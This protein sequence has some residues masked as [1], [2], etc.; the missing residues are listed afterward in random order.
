MFQN[1]TSKPNIFDPVVLNQLLAQFTT[2]APHFCVRLH[3]VSMIGGMAFDGPVPPGPPLREGG[4]PNG[5]AALLQQK[6][7]RQRQL[8][9]E[10]QRSA[11]RKQLGAGVIASASPMQPSP[12][13]AKDWDQVLPELS[14]S[15]TAP[16][17]DARP[18]NSEHKTAPSSP[19]EE[20]ERPEPVKSGT[21][22][23]LDDALDG[24]A[25]EL[26]LDERLPQ[27]AKRGSLEDS[28]GVPWPTRNADGRGKS[29]FGEAKAP[30]PS[31]SLAGIEEDNLYE[32]SFEL[33]ASRPA[34]GM[35]RK[36]QTLILEDGMEQA[37]APSA[38]GLTPTLGRGHTG[39]GHG[40]PQSSGAPSVGKSWDLTVEGA[41]DRVEPVGRR[42]KAEGRSWWPFGGGGGGRD[43]ASTAPVEVKE[44]E[45]GYRGHCHFVLQLRLGVFFTARRESFPPSALAVSRCPQLGWLL[46]QAFQEAAIHLHATAVAAAGVSPMWI[47]SRGKHCDMA[48]S[49]CNEE[50]RD[51]QR[52]VRAESATVRLRSGYFPCTRR[53]VLQGNLLFVCRDLGSSTLVDP[54]K[55]EDAVLLQDVQVQRNGRQCSLTMA[56]GRRIFLT[57]PE[58]KVEKWY[59]LLCRASDFNHFHDKAMAGIVTLL[60]TAKQALGSEDVE[61]FSSPQ[62]TLQEGATPWVFTARKRVAPEAPF[63]SGPM[64][65][66]EP[67]AVSSLSQAVR[68][69]RS[70]PRGGSALRGSYDAGQLAVLT[71]PRSP[72]ALNAKRLAL[73]QLNFEAS[74]ITAR[75]LPSLP[76]R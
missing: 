58:D 7:T 10:K 9:L 12:F 44:E 31:Q 2:A 50:L 8:A 66:M 65:A 1:T 36:Q 48:R 22:L 47:P 75:D 37:Q 63:S 15:P 61:E 17:K 41:P 57:F 55:V 26:L 21:K 19:T 39:A 14:M 68:R 60:Q 35:K 5:G 62:R 67:V 32:A 30:R 34:E 49:G 25:E 40:G 52:G 29:G 71:A 28:G 54:S 59:S 6:M 11:A 42:S 13:R 20:V 4:P 72:K 69:P 56:G 33:P 27:A 16:R 24:L 70:A 73:Q 23:D 43:V 38:P 45:K 53:V 51:L 3:G 18:N 76:G 64:E 74:Q 46:A